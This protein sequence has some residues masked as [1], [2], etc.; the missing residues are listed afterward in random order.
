M[1]LNISIKHA[2]LDDVFAVFY[3]L[4]EATVADAWEGE[5]VNILQGYLDKGCNL[6]QALEKLDEE[7]HKQ[8]EEI[9][10]KEKAREEANKKEKPIKQETKENE[11]HLEGEPP[12]P[13]ETGVTYQDVAN[14]ASELAQAGK[15][16]V[17]RN[18]LD[19]YK[20]PKIVNIKE[21]DLP[22]VYQKLKEAGVENAPF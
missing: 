4:G 16:K 22:E 18:I 6:Y 11:L 9:E 19:E 2:T 7:I 3:R 15:A 1:E 13:E 12:R 21:A 14:L 8:I 10:K 17:L 5:K 20:A